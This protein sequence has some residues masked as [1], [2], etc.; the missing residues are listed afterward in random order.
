[1]LIDSRDYLPLSPSPT[2]VAFNNEATNERC[3]Q[4]P[5]EDG[6]G[7]DCNSQ[8]SRPIIKHVREHSRYDC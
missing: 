1:M 4:R 3:Q 5:C 8:S 2:Q 7:E 6:H